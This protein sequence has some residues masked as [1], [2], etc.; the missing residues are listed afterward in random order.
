MTAT[1]RDWVAR[2]AN[3]LVLIVYGLLASSSAALSL[4]ID[5]RITPLRNG[6][7]MDRDVAQRLLIANAT[8]DIL[9]VVAICVL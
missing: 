2:T 9:S 6:R 4:S 3:T 7:D 1:A 8:V 5:P